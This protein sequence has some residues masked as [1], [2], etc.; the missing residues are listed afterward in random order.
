P[1]TGSCL[2]RTATDSAAGFTLD[3]SARPV[4]CKKKVSASS[5]AL[6]T[7]NYF[8]KNF[9]FPLV[10][11]FDVGVDQELPRGFLGTFE[12]LYSVSSSTLLMRDRNLTGPV[13]ADR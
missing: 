1:L 9:K 3:P 2:S 10:W 5:S 12:A 8:D 4:V 7:V 13:G 6:M 11:K